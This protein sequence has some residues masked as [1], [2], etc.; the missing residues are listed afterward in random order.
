MG[1]AWD[2]DETVE[3]A[4]RSLETVVSPEEALL[5]TGG[6]SHSCDGQ[7]MIGTETSRFCEAAT[8]FRAAVAC[9]LG[10]CR[11]HWSGAA[12]L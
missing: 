3:K 8:P 5:S 1:L 6:R 4:P 9:G 11:D 2:T 12:G 10:A 7:R